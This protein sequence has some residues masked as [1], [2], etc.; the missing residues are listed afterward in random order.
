M[1][2]SFR[3]LVGIVGLFLSLSCSAP[4]RPKLYPGPVLPPE[5]LAVVVTYSQ[6][7]YL[8][9]IRG[10]GVDVGIDPRDGPPMYWAGDSID[11]PPGEY[12]IV[13][14]TRGKLFESKDWTI[15]RRLEAGHLYVPRVEGSKPEWVGT[16]EDVEPEE[17]V[18]ENP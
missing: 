6:N 10:N 15:T 8:Q 5:S 7:A 18:G 3:L 4:S 14:G 2:A 11:V 16:M 1:T 12:T 13:V 9:S 17:G